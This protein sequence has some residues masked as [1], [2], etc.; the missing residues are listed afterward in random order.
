[1]EKLSHFSSKNISVYTIFNDH[2]FND[3]LTN[4]IVSFVQSFV[5]LSSSLMTKLLPVIAKV[6]SDKSV[7]LLQKYIFSA[8]NI[9]VLQI[10]QDRKFN[11]TLS[12]NFI[13]LNNWAQVAKRQHKYST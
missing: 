3:T 5:S 10:F 13:V 7:L 1:M 9:N 4:N 6:F 8:K 12:N 2:S 11:I